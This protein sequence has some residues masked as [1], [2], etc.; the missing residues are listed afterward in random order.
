MLR[1]KN[2]IFDLGNVLYDIEIPRA[3]N[4]F[5]SILGERYEAVHHTHITSK[6]FEK[7]GTNEINAE[8]FVRNF[9]NAA[10]QVVSAEEVVA[11]WNSILLG[12][13][14]YRLKLLKDLSKKYQLYLLSNT[15]SIHMD[16]IRKHMLEEHGIE[17][18]DALFTKA[19]YS[20]EIGLR[21]PNRMIYE[22]VLKDANLVAGESVFIDDLLE[23]IEAAEQVGI[24]G[25]WHKPASIPLEEAIANFLKINE[26]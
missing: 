26:S 4:Y 24:H 7:F 8:Q 10:S 16:H 2:I 5:K 18:F 15:N 20:H 22:H 13:P 25:I 17:N 19:Y 14:A 12:F 9:Q 11:G 1:I 23:N 6:F 3:H 21:K